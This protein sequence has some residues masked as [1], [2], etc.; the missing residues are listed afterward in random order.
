MAAVDQGVVDYI[1]SED[2]RKDVDK[3]LEA[4][5][6]S[7]PHN[8]AF[9][10]TFDQ[11]TKFGKFSSAQSQKDL[12]FFGTNKFRQDLVIYPDM[13]A[14]SL[15][16]SFNNFDQAVAG[17]MLKAALKE[18]PY[19]AE[20]ILVKGVIENG[21]FH[22]FTTFY[23]HTTL[24]PC[25]NCCET[26]QQFSNLLGVPVYVTYIRGYKKKELEIEQYEYHVRAAEHNIFNIPFT[27]GQVGEP[28]VSIGGNLNNQ[29]FILT[30]FP[31]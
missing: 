3:H 24:S 11:A 16:A 4:Y 20:A 26:I 7:I 9:L 30:F 18:S 6:A 28:L 1:L 10:I 19:C 13:N 27:T 25:N 31:A 5:Q 14:D 15:N 8:Q 17:M 29:A 23:I 12:G 22:P 21:G 2:N